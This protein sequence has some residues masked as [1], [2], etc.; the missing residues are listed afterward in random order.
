MRKII[1]GLLITPACF[2]AG[3][4]DNSMTAGGVPAAPHGGIMTAVPGGKGYAEFKIDQSAKGAK[5]GQQ[6]KS[7]IAAFFYQPDGTTEMSPAPTDVTVKLGTAASS[8][9]LTLTPQP[10]DKGK[11]S[12]EPADL[13]EGFKGQL[14]AKINGEAVQVSFSIR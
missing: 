11:F 14:D 1:L 10:N 5:S 3:C 13:P 12:S 2:L 4:G 7:Q 8:P 6:V 9:T